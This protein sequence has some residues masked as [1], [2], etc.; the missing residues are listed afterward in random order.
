VKTLLATSI[1][2]AFL[3]GAQEAGAP[4]PVELEP[5]HHV[6][7]KNA[8]VVV[9]HLILPA[10]ERTLY[11]THT[12]DRVAVTLSS[13]SITQQKLDEAEGAASTTAP[14]KFSAMTLEGSSYTHR[15]HNVGSEAFEVLDVEL[16][17]RPRTP[18]PVEA[19]SVAA[20]N[21]SARVYSWELAAGATSAA[22]APSRPYLI[23]ATTEF[24]LKTTAPEGQSSTH[25]MKRGDFRWVDSKAL[26]S[27]GNAGKSPGQ[28]LEI[29]LK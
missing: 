16:V 17:E 5:L 4:V 13:T 26:H 1:V 3:G 11:H 8:S 27:L 2:L 18:S 22:H 19:A 20:E 14:G 28:I 9:L 6:V 23:V 7:L 15:V 29:E 25:P 24:L 21:P 12:H 10:G